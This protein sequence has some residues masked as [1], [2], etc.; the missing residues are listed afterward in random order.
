MIDDEAGDR[1]RVVV[2]QH[3]PERQQVDDDREARV[4]DDRQGAVPAPVVAEGG[5][6]KRAHLP[7][8]ERELQAAEYKALPLHAPAHHPHEEVLAAEE[9]AAQRL[10]RARFRQLQEKDDGHDAGEAQDVH[11]VERAP[12]RLLI[13]GYAAVDARHQR[14]RGASWRACE[15]PAAASSGRP[16]R[17]VGKEAA[18]EEWVPGEEEKGQGAPRERARLSRT[19]KTTSVPARRYHFDGFGGVRQISGGGPLAV[20]RKGFR[21]V[22]RTDPAAPAPRGPA[23]SGEP[24][25]PLPPPTRPLG[26]PPQRMAQVASSGEAIVQRTERCPS[27]RMSSTFITSVARFSS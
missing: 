21:R 6:E 19:Y 27:S 14:A 20:T 13:P 7:H 3:R 26:E 5:E 25:I 2:L 18:V 1:Q 24:A 10:H 22:P 16:T 4:D 8:Q 17:G 15:T 11:A 23:P 12:L 9:E